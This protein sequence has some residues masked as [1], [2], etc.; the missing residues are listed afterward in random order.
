MGLLYKEIKK[1]T[2][3]IEMISRA[4]EKMIP[5]YI[6]E[7]YSHLGNDYELIGAFEEAIKAYRKAYEHDKCNTNIVFQLVV[8]YD[9]YY[10]DK[11]IPLMY[12]EKYLRGTNLENENLS[13]YANSR[14]ESIKE[15]LHFRKQQ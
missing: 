10:E 1:Y 2:S 12:Y 11:T 14:I 3:S 15:Y 13:E 7:A 4:I 6:T 5:G 8:L 9:K